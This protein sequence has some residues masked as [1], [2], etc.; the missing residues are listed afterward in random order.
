M[1]P[2]IAVVI[3][4]IFNLAN[5]DVL[6]VVVVVIVVIVVRNYRARVAPGTQ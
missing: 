1:D 3:I 6:V 2:D 5:F 4:D